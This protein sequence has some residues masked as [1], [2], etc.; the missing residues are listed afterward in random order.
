MKKIISCLILCAMLL[1]IIPMNVF[2]EGTQQVE[3]NMSDYTPES[4]DKTGKTYLVKSVADL[5]KFN[6]KSPH[7]NFKNATI[8][9]MADIDYSGKTWTGIIFNGTFDGNG[10]TIS[11]VTVG[12]C[13]TVG[14]MFRFAG[15]TIKNLTI[16]G[17]I[18]NQSIGN[19]GGLVGSRANGNVNISSLIIENVHIVNGDVSG[20]GDNVGGIIGTTSGNHSQNPNN[21]NYVK[22]VG[23]SYNGTVSGT[24]YVGGIVG[25]YSFVTHEEGLKIEGC[26]FTGNIGASGNGSGGIIGYA[27]ADNLVISE[28]F[29]NAS[30]SG[31]GNHKG[32]IMGRFAVN[33]G[34]TATINNCVVK[35]S[36]VN[37]YYTT[38]RTGGIIGY[39]YYDGMIINCNNVFVDMENTE[40]LVTVLG[41]YHHSGG[42]GTGGK[43]SGNLTNVRYSEA[44]AQTGKAAISTGIYDSCFTPTGTPTASADLSTYIYGYQDK[45]NDN[46]TANDKTDDTKDYR[47]IGVLNTE[48]AL[49]NIKELGFYVTVTM[50][51]KSVTQ[52]VTCERVYTSVEGGGITYTVNGTEADNVEVVDGNYLYV[53]EL[54]EVPASYVIG[55]YFNVDI[56]TYMVTG[57]S[58]NLTYSYGAA[59]L[60]KN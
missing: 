25:D 1:S 3:I 22:I 60:P 36:I 59:Y 9:L 51:N 41:F 26:S 29:V 57:E 16:N 39:I 17:L 30:F 37:S 31:A 12:T 32:G 52:K 8:K 53:V 48:T 40:S 44:L 35:G 46:G 54:Q 18:C 15:G 49:E 45:T 14:G 20:T 58:D 5:E 6:T 33:G 27:L 24:K 10:Y 55:T 13:S 21:T 50:G 43:S 28:C 4:S 2:A 19:V 23:S 42:N 34:A 11:N 56:T 47:F 38:L 7:T